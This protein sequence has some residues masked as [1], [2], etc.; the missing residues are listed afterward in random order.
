[1]VDG[2]QMYYKTEIVNIIT[3]GLVL[4]KQ[5]DIALNDFFE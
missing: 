4:G 3:P 1:M 2:V 5:L